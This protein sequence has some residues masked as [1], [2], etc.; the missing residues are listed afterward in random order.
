[1]SNIC[2][3]MSVVSAIVQVFEK[4]GPSPMKLTRRGKNV[5]RGLIATSLLVVIGAGF[6]A[7]GN[8]SNFSGGVD[9]THY[10]T[11]VVAP[12]ETLWSLA[13][14]AHTSV[15]AIISANMLTGTDVVA[16]QKLL[17]PSK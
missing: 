12:G 14:L 3:T 6:S 7:V 4:K 11:V 17:V 15:D 10:V 9:K 5:V 16:G 2:S 13:S 1:M 8:A